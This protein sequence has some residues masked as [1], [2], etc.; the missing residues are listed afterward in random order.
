[1]MTAKSSATPIRPFSSAA[2]ALAR[3]GLLALL[4]AAA[5]ACGGKPPGAGGPGGPPGGGAFALPVTVEPVRETE[6]RDS[7]EYVATIKS[8][9][10]ISVQPQV[11][12]LVTRIFVKSG[13]HVAAGAALAQIDEAK[14]RAT[15]KSQEAQRAQRQAA[16]DYARQQ[17]QRMA[18]LY[19]GGAVSKQAL[20]QAETA[21]TQAEADYKALGAQVEEQV[22]QLR[23]FRLVA[24]E[25]GVVGDI[26]VRVGDRVT[27][28][29]VITT[30]EQNSALEVYISVPVERAHD[31][32]LG[33]PVE[34]LGDSGEVATRT[35]VSFVAPQVDDQTQSV[36]VK[37]QVPNSSQAL[38]ADQFVRARIIWNLRRGL[39]VPALAV[40]R[41][42]GQYFVFVAEP[43][44]AQPAP[45]QGGGAGG[46]PGG[47]GPGGGGPGGPGGGAGG[48]GLV[49]HQRP[50][51]LGDLVGNDYIVL[52]GLQPGEKVVTSGVQKLFDGMPVMALPPGPPGPPGSPQAG[53][54]G[55]QAGQKPG[56]QPGQQSG[57]K[58]Q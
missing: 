35:Q 57:P 46:G 24:P 20:E 48:G 58:P 33:L 26:P 6:L 3:L 52:S 34:V 9:R 32:R 2:A 38:R 44:P 10:S 54:G 1:M 15:V 11:E 56:A 40:V 39:V 16:L 23:Y 7:T 37:A 42:N 19:K 55:P 17:A 21:L 45:A 49:A 43:A 27:T 25:A 29:T 50:V 12:G 53:P 4:A 47:G 13:D 8:R 28:S 14:Q 51:K 5:V 18:T 22:V 36:L 30:I 41:I 31:L